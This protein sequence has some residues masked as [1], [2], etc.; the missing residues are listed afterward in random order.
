MLQVV[1]YDSHG[2]LK[3]YIINQ[4]PGETERQFNRRTYNEF[5]EKSHQWDGYKG[6][7]NNVYMSLRYTPE[8]MAEYIKTHQ[9][10]IK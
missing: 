1:M 10:N 3:P 9:I 5:L 4:I 7:G 2:F 8:Q 6:T